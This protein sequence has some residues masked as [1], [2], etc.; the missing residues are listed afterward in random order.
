MKNISSRVGPTPTVAYVHPGYE[1]QDE[2]TAYDLRL[3]ASLAEPVVALIGNATRDGDDFLD[4]L[5][6]QLAGVIDGVQFRRYVRTGVATPLSDEV[7]SDVVA[8]CHAAVL[9]WGH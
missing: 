1:E 6:G 7:F 3:S 4:V 5:E 9:A 8:G 2:G